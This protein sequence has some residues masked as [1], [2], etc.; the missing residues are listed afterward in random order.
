VA[1]R[2]EISIS[3]GFYACLSC[4]EIRCFPW[5]LAILWYLHHH[6]LTRASLNCCCFW[7]SSTHDS[8]AENLHR[9]CRL[10][11]EIS[12]SAYENKHLKGYHSRFRLSL[13]SHPTRIGLTSSLGMESATRS[14]LGS[15]WGSQGHDWTWI[16]DSSSPQNAATSNCSSR[17]K[18]QGFDGFAWYKFFQLASRCLCGLSAPF[19]SPCSV[20]CRVEPHF[21]RTEVRKCSID[22]RHSRY[23][24]I[25]N[26]ILS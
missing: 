12:V 26:L 2:P 14:D 16:S 11:T 7:N 19:R 9:L 22:W 8:W 25:F 13:R 17:W 5:L 1:G 3:W 10:S 23:L 24:Q 18:S 6:P 4:F 21:Q 15:D 20:L